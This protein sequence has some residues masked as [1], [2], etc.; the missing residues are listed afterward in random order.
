MKKHNLVH[1]ISIL[2]IFCFTLGMTYTSAAKKESEDFTEFTCDKGISDLDYQSDR[3]MLGDMQLVCQKGDFR[4]YF[5]PSSLFFAIENVTTGDIFSSNPYNAA[6]SQSNQKALY[7]QLGI[8]YGKNTD[9]VTSTMWSY[10]DCVKLSQFKAYKSKDGVKVVYSVGK[11]SSA[12]VLPEVLSEK[13]F[14]KILDTLSGLAATQTKFLYSEYKKGDTLPKGF[15]DI[16]FDTKVYIINQNLAPNE[17]ERLEQNFANAKF[18]A[19]DL[20]KEYSL[21]KFKADLSDSP[22]FKITVYYKLTQNGL[23][24]RVP[25]KEIKFNK[26]LYYLLDISL[27][28]YFGSQSYNGN[29]GF[30]L[31]PDGSGAI[32]KFSENASGVSQIKN[33][34]YGTDYGITL[35]KEPSTVKA[36]HLPVFGMSNGNS[37]FLGIVEDGSG[38][39]SLCF[40]VNGGIG[41]FY[42]AYPILTYA[43]SEAITTEAKVYSAYST[44]NTLKIDENAYTGDYKVSYNLLC[45]NDIGYFDMARTLKNH[46]FNGDNGYTQKNIELAVQTIGAIKYPSTV[47]GVSYEATGKITSFAQN[48]EILQKLN[49]SGIKDLDLYLSAWR[50]GGFDNQV[51]NRFDPEK[52]LGGKKDLQQL[53]GFC[54]KKDIGIYADI[55]FA[56]AVKDRLFDNFSATHDSVKLLTSKIGGKMTVRPDLGEYDRDTFVYAL[57]PV[58]Y[59][60]Y[61]NKFVS[62][63]SK[64][65]ISSFAVNDTGMSLNSTFKKNSA[66]NREQALNLVCEALKGVSQKAKLSFSGANDYIL[67]Y[68]SRLTDIP[69]CDSSLKGVSYDIPFVQLV[70]YGNIPYSSCELNSESNI[71]YALLK[72][73]SAISS[74]KFVIGMENM[75]KIKLS[76]YTQYNSIAFNTRLDD[77]TS[78]YEYVF[79]AFK[80][81]IGEKL[82]NHT[83]LS[84]GIARLEYS[85]GVSIYVNATN[86]D[87]SKD[88]IFVPAM[89]YKVFE[90]EEG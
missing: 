28:R 43:K 56:F 22:N 86:N 60:N 38:L 3:E 16:S 49:D 13:T 67:N 34:L 88:N 58:K 52:E 7:S 31:I 68:A 64:N 24:V 89:D 87:Y 85:N 61:L 59:K 29:D 66:I 71:R 75:D 23:S 11:D 63:A 15:E 81:V 44:N 53:F 54:D 1:F 41:S 12:S 83:T 80:S 72:C 48:K 78:A 19:D 76:K 18:S 42:T 25:A 26:S 55:T 5:D 57:S 35:P 74:P 4:F 30:I 90:K 10:D 32:V 17:K 51:L 40:D 27:L 21:L 82:V 2:L 84:D 65:K 14:N 8:S 37:A 47:L 33:E 6:S 77:L 46:Y 69:V 73:I 20:K 9:K 62:K 50:C 45:G 70:C 39:T 36:W 79:G